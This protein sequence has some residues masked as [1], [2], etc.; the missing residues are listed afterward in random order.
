MCT[1]LS[2]WV[3]GCLVACLFCISFDSFWCSCV[4]RM[5]VSQYAARLLTK[6]FSVLLAT[7]LTQRNQHSRQTL[8]QRRFTTL[9]FIMPTARRLFHLYVCECVPPLDLWSQSAILHLACLH[10]T[11]LRTAFDLLLIRHVNN[12]ANLF[13]ELSV[14][15]CAY[16]C[17]CVTLSILILPHPVT[18]FPTSNIGP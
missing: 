1:D 11:L 2:V 7:W 17:V 8:L 14:C 13:L 12:V 15:E 6:S 9:R 4:S 18:V 5:F 16:I 3:F 10:A